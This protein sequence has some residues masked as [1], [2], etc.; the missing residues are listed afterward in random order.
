MVVSFIK[1]RVFFECLG[2]EKVEKLD[3]SNNFIV[4]FP[5]VALK[6]FDDLKILNLSSNLIQVKKKKNHSQS[7]YLSVFNINKSL[8]F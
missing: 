7:I 1:K 8:L 5:S 3:V 6:K 4:E 2:A